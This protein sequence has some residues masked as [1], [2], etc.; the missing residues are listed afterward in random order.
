MAN[1]RVSRQRVH[2][3]ERLPL[4]LALALCAAGLAL[5]Q[6][7]RADDSAT[8]PTVT[9]NADQAA[10]ALAPT[11]GYSAPTTRAA[12]KTDTPL[13]E[14]AQSVSVVTRRQIEDQNPK[15][16]AEALNYTPGVYSASIGSSTRYDYIVLRG[17]N[18]HVN[19]NEWLDGLRLLGDAEGSNALQIDP[20]A[21]ERIDVVRG[22]DS[23]A[24]GQSS[25]GGLVALTSKRPL[26]TAQR[27]IE[28]GVGSHS[29]RWLG[30][31]LTGPVSDRPDLSYRLLAKGQAG[32][33]Q[34]GFAS[35]ERYLLAP[36]LSWRIDGRNRL[37]L[38][39]YL[40]NDPATGYHGSVPYYGSVVARNGR[41]LA[42]GFDDGSPTDGMRRTEQLYGY[43]F[44]HDFN[45]RWQ[46]RQNLRYQKSRIASQQVYQA[47]WI[48]ASD[49]L[50][51]YAS[52]GQESSEGFT[53]DNQLQGRFETG[54]VR[55]TL[56]AGVD[57][58][59]LKNDGYNRYGTASSIDAY[60]PSYSSENIVFGAPVFF[61]HRVEQ[62][63]VYLNDQLAL[64]HW[65]LDLGVRQDHAEIKSVTVASGATS[66]WDGD[67]TTK[68]VGLSYVAD[69]G[70]TPY[71][72]Y[73]EG[74]DPSASYYTDAS[75]NIL[76][77][78][79]SKQK[80]V[81]LK[82]QPQGSQTQLAVAAY[83][84][85][86]ENVA[87]RNPVTLVYEPVGVVRSRGVELEAKT[88]V[89]KRLSLMASMTFNSMKIVEGT[90]KDHTPFGA[91]SRMASAWADY[92][93]D[94]GLSVG[95][96]LRYIG[97]QWADSAN[98][99]R[100]A[101]VTLV[102]LSLRYDLGRFDSSLKGAAL[103]LTASNLFDRAYVA[104][105]YNS[106]NYCYAGDRRNLT[107]AVN[108]QW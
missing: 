84:L 1:R 79:Q 25:P 14:T 59:Q 88:R 24:Y 30:I 90:E 10:D 87:Y 15:T 6:A 103:R 47:G 94:T 32:G 68:R 43:Q 12:T 71:A 29:Q 20:W 55:H 8:L 27:Q 39:A 2:D 86:Q 51:R 70:L 67:K 56:L 45:D 22:P 11:H 23:V 89:G 46:F 40:Q 80:E 36:S 37:L 65:R 44:E 50:T 106:L 81:G 82:F 96:G 108:Y 4:G 18:D 100:L 31:D 33:T 42:S 99:V 54:A 61:S 107:A 57:A 9:V 34:Q 95:G 93:F 92:A 73:S 41:T 60:A 7:A 85:R 77:P 64:D 52:A 58:Y 69:N 3:G 104:S 38:Q 49:M 48:G 72:S 98:T 75:G 13:N 76:S 35:T 5:G 101:S 28:L 16:L 66:R 62:T 19:T 53:F 97:P 78:Q 91:P 26:D 83:D 105:C 21:I 102:D 63:G 17:F 74:F